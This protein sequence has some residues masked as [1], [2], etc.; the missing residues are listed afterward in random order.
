MS[1]DSAFLAVG[2]SGPGPKYSGPSLALIHPS[3]WKYEILGSSAILGFDGRISY[4]PL[5]VQE[6]T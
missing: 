3:A 6:H 1:A 5:A 2:V 4:S